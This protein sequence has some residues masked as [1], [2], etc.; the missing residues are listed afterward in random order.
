MFERIGDLA[1]QI[2][3]F[4][5]TG[6]MTRKETDKIGRI[7]KDAIDEKGPIRLFLV[8]EHYANMNSA[9]ALYEDLKFAKLHSDGI[10]R[11]AVIGD[12]AWKE[13]WVALFGLFG[14]IDAR[15][16]DATELKAAWEWIRETI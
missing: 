3:A 2:I 1:D 12:R 15:Y 8:M 13:T 4:K 6:E 11:M 16:F 5:F 9:E 7:L 10:E 14:G